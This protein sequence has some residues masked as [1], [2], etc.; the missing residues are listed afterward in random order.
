[1]PVL[2]A[3]SVA[4]SRK[5][6]AANNPGWTRGRRWHLLAIRCFLDRHSALISERQ[7]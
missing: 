4:G 1:M 2:P 7:I 6:N 3:I 5:H